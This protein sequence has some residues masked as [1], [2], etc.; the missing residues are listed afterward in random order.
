MGKVGSL[1][2][3]RSRCLAADAGLGRFVSDPV[4]TAVS[5]QSVRITQLDDLSVIYHRTSGMTHVVD[6][7]VPEIFDVL[8]AAPCT[9][10]A[11]LNELARSHDIDADGV[12][13]QA[14]ITR[15][16]ELCALGL[17]SRA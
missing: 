9:A 15:L 4:Y 1:V 6:Q 13:S 8:R 3:R 11:L 17:V 16:D 5:A 7:A 14:L 2:L 10:D 12:A